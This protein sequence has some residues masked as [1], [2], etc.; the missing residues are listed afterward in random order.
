MSVIVAVEGFG[1]NWF[2]AVND[3]FNIVTILDDE[4]C[5]DQNWNQFF[6]YLSEDCSFSGEV[7]IIDVEAV[8]VDIEFAFKDLRD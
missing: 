4:V 7:D 1:V 6:I 2:S 8:C 3:V 5:I